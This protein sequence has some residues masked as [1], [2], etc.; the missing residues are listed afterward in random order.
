M[1]K[2]VEMEVPPEI[3]PLKEAGDLNLRRDEVSWKRMQ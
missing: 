3:P 2:M 1:I